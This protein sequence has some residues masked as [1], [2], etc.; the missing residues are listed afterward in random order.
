MYP[1]SANQCFQPER[2]SMSTS[3]RLLHPHAASITV[4]GVAE[5]CQ[6]NSSPL[7][8][9]GSI[10]FRHR[11]RFPASETTCG[12]GCKPGQTR[13]P[14]MVT[15]WLTSCVRTPMGS[16]CV[17]PTSA[18]RQWGPRAAAS[19]GAA[20]SAACGGAAPRG[21]PRA[22]RLPQHGRSSRAGC[23]G[24][25][26]AVAAGRRSADEPGDPRAARFCGDH[27][28]ATLPVAMVQGPAALKSMAD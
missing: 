4:T 28:D 24:S 16:D 12:S 18:T 9:S 1:T 23:G 20:G 11:Q 22:W 25:R 26:R 14:N 8:R 6:S 21:I 5:R 10:A 17:L 2:R 19:G 27:D 13:F 7:R 15:A 3:D